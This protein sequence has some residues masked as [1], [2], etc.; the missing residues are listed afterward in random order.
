MIGDGFNIDPGNYILVYC[1]MRY[2][3]AWT[4]RTLS[5]WFIVLA[6]ADRYFSSSPS[7]SRRQL[8]S[9][10]TAY[11]TICATTVIGLLIYVHVLVYFNIDPT[12]TPACYGM[13]GMYR[14][15][16]DFSYLSFYSVIPTFV[17]CI[18]GSLTICN[19]I[20]L[21][22]NVSRS[23]TAAAAFRIRRRDRQ[24]LLMLLCQVLIIILTTLAQ[25]AQ[26][27]YATFTTATVKTSMDRA[28]DEL[29]AQII[30][31]ISF[32]SHCCSCY[33]FTIISG[34]YRKELNLVLQRCYKW[35]LFQSTHY[36][37]S[38]DGNRTSEQL[39][40]T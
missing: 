38:D 11:Y 14:L 32:L 30:R 22:Q 2:Y 4:S 37:R 33:I 5:T 35:K 36:T 15:F 26:K 25:P 24:M 28:H 40:Q 21:H 8:S 3:I 12:Q 1:K 27:L 9:I 34:R 7:V 31:S 16:A 23:T 29:A 6:C 20:E 13:Q 10:T 18:F 39:P 17:M 19:V